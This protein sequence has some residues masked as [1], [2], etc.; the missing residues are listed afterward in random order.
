MT[1]VI[2]RADL[3]GGMDTFGPHDMPSCRRCWM[4][5]GISG[6]Y[7]P[8]E[9]LQIACGTVPGDTRYLDAAAENIAIYLPKSRDIENN[10]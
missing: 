5:Y 10:G 9:Q 2:C 1:C 3:T 7:D 8:F 6:P 4:E